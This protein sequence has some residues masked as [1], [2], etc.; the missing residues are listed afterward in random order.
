M[1]K[2]S[3][4]STANPQS[5][6][7]FWLDGFLTDAQCTFVREELEF[8]FWHRSQVIKKVKDNQI[9]SFQS[10]ART[11]ETSA[12]EW[13]SDEL[14]DFMGE[15]E[16]R[17]ETLLNTSRQRFEYWQATRYSLNGLFD[18][19]H[20]A[21]Y[22][23]EDQAGERQR[24]V[25]LYLDTPT[26][27]GHTHFRALDVSV[28]AVAGRL[29]IWNNLLPTGCCNYGMIHASMPVLEGHKTTLVTWERLS[30]CRKEPSN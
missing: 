14:L 10:P 17:L 30:T 26:R 20:D 5:K 11:S 22:W 27:G 18:Y 13:F 21:G 23:G 12:Q 24:T 7:V 3:E 16:T 2:L 4:P 1:K 28:Q 25:L 19:H 9:E 6:D 29:L 8:S 15:L